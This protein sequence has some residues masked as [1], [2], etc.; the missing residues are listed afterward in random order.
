VPFLLA[1]PVLVSLTV[2]VAALEDRGLAASSLN[3]NS[4]CSADSA[5]M[6]A[7]WCSSQPNMPITV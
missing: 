1:L 4:A 5:C 6:T 3:M 7:E 2:D